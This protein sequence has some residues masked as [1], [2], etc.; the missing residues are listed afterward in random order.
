MSDSTLYLLKAF[1]LGII[2]GLTEFIPVSSTG[3]LILFGDWIQ[4]ESSSGK[5]FEVVIQLG[6]ILAVMWIFR[7]RLWQLIRG[8]LCGERQELLFTRNLMLAFLPA[9]VIGAIFIK[10][11]KQTFYH[12]GVVAVTLVIGGLIMLWVERRAPHTPGDAPGA[13][14]DTA[15]DERATARR[16][17]DISWKQALGVGVAQCLAMIPGTSRSGAT[18]IGGMIAGIQRKTATEFSFF[19]AMPTMLGAAVYDM[20]RNMDVLTS[21]DLSG[22][23]VGFVAAF[24]SALVVV[25]AVLRFVANHTYRGFAWYRIAL[26]LVVAVWLLSK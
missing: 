6:S 25:R 23:A 20:Y 12:P 15:S 2:E 11:I 18:I 19:L 14:D 26:G 8:T 16:L 4:F 10:S 5:V 13:A 1:F 7:A 21:H 22:I 9:A 17:E 3:H 24:L